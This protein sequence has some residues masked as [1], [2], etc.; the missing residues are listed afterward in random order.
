MLTLYLTTCSVHDVLIVGMTCHQIL[1]TSTRFFPLK[2]KL[3]V[4]ILA[5][6][7][8]VA[9]TDL[10]SYLT[11]CL[12]LLSFLF[13]LFLLESVIPIYVVILMI[14]FNVPLCFRFYL[15]LF[16]MARFK[17]FSIF[18]IISFSFFSTFI[19]HLSPNVNLYYPIPL[20]HRLF[21]FPLIF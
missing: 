1:L 18:L 6:I 16:Y 2:R 4:S 17:T 11:I 21:Y 9:P 5:P 15:C 14:L 20:R 3:I 8:R 10:F 13:F 12:V 7:S 19:L